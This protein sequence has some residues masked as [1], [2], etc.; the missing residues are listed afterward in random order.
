VSF[1]GEVDIEVCPCAI[2][3]ANVDLPLP[4]N[5]LNRNNSLV[6]SLVV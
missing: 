4:G 1:I 3:F 5:P 6:V 2:D